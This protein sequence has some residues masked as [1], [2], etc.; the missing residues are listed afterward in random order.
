MIFLSYIPLKYD[1]SYYYI[2]VWYNV[3]SYL[4]VTYDFPS[5]RIHV[6]DYF[7]FVKKWEAVSLSIY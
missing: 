6:R 2:P 1:F 7:S 4:P 5:F 3:F